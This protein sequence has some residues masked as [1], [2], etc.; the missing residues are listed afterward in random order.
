MSNG[1]IS[2][3]SH[4][5]VSVGVNEKGLKYALSDARLSNSYPLG[6]SNEFTGER[7]LISV[8]DGTLIII[9]SKKAKLDSKGDKL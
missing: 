5:S 1:Y 8:K 9:Y 3:F 7:S 2:V 6:V 4:S